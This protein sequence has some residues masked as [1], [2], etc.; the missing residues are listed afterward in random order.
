[1]TLEN[2]QQAPRRARDA[3]RAADRHADAG[4]ESAYATAADSCAEWQRVHDHTAETRAE[5]YDPDHDTALLMGGVWV[6]VV[7]CHQFSVAGAR[8]L[9][10]SA[11]CC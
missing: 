10:V 1:M 2:I 11:P 3:E 6:A 8:S 4:D 9:L 5:R 7:T